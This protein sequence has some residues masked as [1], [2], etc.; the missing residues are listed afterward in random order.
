MKYIT[1]TT[2]F[3]GGEKIYRWQMVKTAGEIS[4]FAGV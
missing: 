3:A 1:S 4:L 2:I